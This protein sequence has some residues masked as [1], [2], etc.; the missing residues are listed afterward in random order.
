MTQVYAGTV[1]Q[2]GDVPVVHARG[3]QMRVLAT[4]ATVGATQ[5]IM[6]H[7]LLQP[8]EEI[9]EHLHDYG[10]ESVFVMRGQGTVFIEDVPYP[11]QEQCVFLVAKGL[12]HRVVNEGP[13]DMELV[14]A[15]A[16]LAPRP[17]IGHRDV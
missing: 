1:V 12:R 10:E 4:P 2:F 7:V 8:G 13:G 16:P 14:F 15:T 3:G 5:L 17:E 6:G 11:L 9:K